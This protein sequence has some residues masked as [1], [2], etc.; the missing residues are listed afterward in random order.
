LINKWN[1]TIERNHEA[2]VLEYLRDVDCDMDNRIRAVQ[3]KKEMDEIMELY[4]LDEDRGA[5]IQQRYDEA[6]SFNTELYFQ[7][8]VSHGSSGGQWQGCGSNKS[9]NLKTVSLHCSTDGAIHDTV[10]HI[11]G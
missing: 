8:T 5:T 11:K 3:E 7:G 9:R 1:N 4:K 6:S 10:K 2:G